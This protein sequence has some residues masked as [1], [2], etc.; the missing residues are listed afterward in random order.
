MPPEVFAAI[1]A[2][3]MVR[4][5]PVPERVVLYPV[6]GTQPV[7]EGVYRRDPIAGWAFVVL[8]D[9]RPGAPRIAAW[10]VALGA[11]KGAFRP[12]VPWPDEPTPGEIAGS[13]GRTHRPLSDRDL[14]LARRGPPAGPTPSP[15]GVTGPL[16]TQEVREA[17]REAM[18]ARAPA[19]EPGRRPVGDRDL[20]AAREQARLRG[21][22][23]P[24]G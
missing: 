15:A 7:Y 19:P 2:M 23:P 20:D 4:A 10:R 8:A 9:L 18:R 21:A 17:W 12:S 6:D 13:R 14:A 22:L 24:R 11:L 16:R 1:L 5:A 3:A